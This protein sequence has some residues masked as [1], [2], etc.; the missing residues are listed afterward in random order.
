MKSDLQERLS[1]LPKVDVLLATP[2]AEELLQAFSRAQVVDGVRAQL[3]A[4]RKQMLQGDGHV[5]EFAE[6]PFFDVV[7]G[8]LRAKQQPS[9]RRV[10]N[11]TGIVLHTNLGRAPLAERAIEAVVE[12]ARGYSNLEYDLAAG[13]RGSRHAHVERLLCELTGAEAAVV[14]NNN[15]AAVM[16][17]VNTLAKDAEVVTSR[18]ELIEIGGSFRIPDVIERSEAELV[19]VGTTNKT[20]IDDYANAI[21]DRTRILLKVHQSN[22]KI[23]GFTSAAKREEMVALARERELLVVEDLGSGILI[24]PAAFGLPDETTVREAV[25]AGVD[26]VTFSGDKLLGGPQAG[27]VVGR[28]D[29]IAAMKKNPLMRAL[30][31][32][33]LD[34]AALEATLLLYL[35]EDRLRESLP[36]LAMLTASEE[37]LK[38]KAQTLCDAL[39]AVPGVR[40]E[41]KQG[42][43]Y[44]G[45]GS[46]PDEALPSWV[47]AV[48]SEHLSA[49]EL[50][51]ALR[52]QSPPI[53]A[54]IAAAALNLDVR[55][56]SE[57]EID[58]IA[59][60]FQRIHDLP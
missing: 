7:E 32:G 16:L 6:V 57:E 2:R 36:V 25:G 45:G 17:A 11:A 58:E 9:L 1:K 28:S 43:S 26:L 19:E 30:R 13:K 5:Y 55:T 27:I 4:L 34:L 18:G 14:V 39:G 40:A 10:I 48:R 46:L 56:V 50:A 22:F 54:R 33:K 44:A 53:V 42:E 52:A 12:V 51:D 20:R 29:L 47:A 21:T 23:V 8:D 31:P 15:A 59:R 38:A 37:E 35:D 3:E 49:N 24:D 41:L 60:A